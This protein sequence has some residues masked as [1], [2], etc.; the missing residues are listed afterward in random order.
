MDIFHTI[1]LYEADFS[2]NNKILGMKMMHQAEKENILAQEQYGSRKNKMVIQ[3]ALNKR[4]TFDI[5]RTTKLPAG[6]CSCD[7][8]LCYDII[9]HSFVSLAI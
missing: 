9:F 8:K 3:C 1:L 5:L 6:I 7:L 4:L 2:L